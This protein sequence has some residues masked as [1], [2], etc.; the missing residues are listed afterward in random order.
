MNIAGEI[1][2]LN[3]KSKRLSN[4]L[5][6]H[7]IIYEN[8]YDR[9]TISLSSGERISM[10]KFLEYDFAKDIIEEIQQYKKIIGNRQKPFLIYFSCYPPL[11]KNY[12]LPNH[13]EKQIDVF[14]AEIL[15]KYNNGKTLFEYTDQYIDIPLMKEFQRIAEYNGVYL[16]CYCCEKGLD[17]IFKKNYS[18]LDFKYLDLYLYKSIM[19]VN[20]E[21]IPNLDVERLDKKFISLNR[22]YECH[23]NIIAAFLYRRDSIISWY[24][25][26]SWDSLKN[27]LWF[28]IDNWKYTHPCLYGKISKGHQHL[29]NNVPV[30]VDEDETAMDLQGNEMD[31][32]LNPFSHVVPF[33]EDISIMEKFSQAF[34]SVVN[35]SRFADIGSYIDEKAIMPMLCKRPFILVGKAGSLELLKS[36]GFLTFSDFWDESY[37]EIQNHEK[38]L[39]RILE[40]IDYIDSMSKNNLKEML[41]EMSFILDHNQEQIT[42]IRNNIFG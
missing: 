39:I 13:E 6:R 12:V 34:C 11:H 7:R 14:F 1:K 32:T 18:H 19:Y 16:T 42:K 38:R 20:N 26:G 23:R 31:F 30:I 3:K 28:E 5:Q 36:Y 41:K 15:I 22:R 8:F 9:E 2:K 24:F 33:L 37:D 35:L 4:N 10:Q 29:N 25:L 27:N 40:L 17:K 21:L